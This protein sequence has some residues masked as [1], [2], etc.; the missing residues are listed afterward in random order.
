MYSRNISTIRCLK[1]L[2][3]LNYCRLQFRTVETVKGNYF[4]LSTLNYYYSLPDTTKLNRLLIFLNGKLA[5]YSFSDQALCVEVCIHH[6]WKSTLLPVQ[7]VDCYSM[8]ENWFAERQLHVWAV[9]RDL[10][11]SRFSRLNRKSLPIVHWTPPGH[12]LKSNLYHL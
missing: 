3:F 7:Q 10:C 4:G 11:S 12:H 6:S 9:Y 5:T 8:K 2:I 1:E